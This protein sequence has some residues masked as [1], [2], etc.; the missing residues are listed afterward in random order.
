[1]SE[2][3]DYY[4]QTLLFNLYLSSHHRTSVFCRVRDTANHPLMPLRSQA[5]EIDSQL[6]QLLNTLSLDS[7]RKL[8]FVSLEFHP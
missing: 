3:H 2:Y 6:A 1:M 5:M 7:Q 4:S 8:T